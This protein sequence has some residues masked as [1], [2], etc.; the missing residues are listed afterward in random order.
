MFRQNRGSDKCIM[1]GYTRDLSEHQFPS[2]SDHRL[3]E[4]VMRIVLLSCLLQCYPL[5]NSHSRG[6]YMYKPRH[7]MNM[8]VALIE[9]RGAD[10]T[11]GISGLCLALQIKKIVTTVYSELSWFYIYYKQ[12]VYYPYV[13]CCNR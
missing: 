2:L 13:L 9:W 6:T 1:L 4:R 11:T 7:Y 12:V 8:P 10:V 3:L 5:Y